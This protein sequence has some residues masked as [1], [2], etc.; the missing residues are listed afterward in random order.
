MINSVTKNGM[1]FTKRQIERAKNVRAIYAK[2]GCPSIAD[3]KSMIRYQMI[4]NCPITLEDVKI[5]EE[6]FGP[7]IHGLKGKTVPK[8][9]SRVETNYIALP[10][11]ILKNHRSV[12]L[13]GD[14]FVNQIPFFITLSRNIKFNTIKTMTGLKQKIHMTRA[15]ESLHST[16]KEVL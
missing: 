15:K 14:F 2:I 8:N 3:F 1:M 4:N 5:A 12:T 13:V 11:G 7:D 10:K 9:P 16:T 6:V